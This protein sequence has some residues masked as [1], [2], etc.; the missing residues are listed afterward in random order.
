MQRRD[1]NENFLY[2][3]RL[4][5]YPDDFFSSTVQ[6]ASPAP[7]RLDF[8]NGLYSRGFYHLAALEYRK[9]LQ[10]HPQGALRELALY[11]LGECYR[12]LGKE[13]AAIKIYQEQLEDF[14][15]GERARHARYRL[16]QLFLKRG[17]YE[18]ASGHLERLIAMPEAGKLRE[19]SLLRLGECYQ[20]LGRPQKALLAWSKIDGESEVATWAAFRIGSVLLKQGE[21]EKAL[22]HFARVAGKEESPLYAEANFQRGEILHS[23]GRAND[24][25]K[26]YLAAARAFARAG[27]NE[28]SLFKYILCRLRL[29]DDRQALR[30]GKS[31]LKSFPNSGRTG[32]VL[33]LVGEA[34]SRLGDY[35][36]ALR[37]LKKCRE[38]KLSPP[39]APLAHFRE[40]ECYRQQKQWERAATSFR[41]FIGAFADHPLKEEALLRLGEAQK[42][43]A[44]FPGASKTLER[45][46]SAYPDSGHQERAMYLLGICYAP[47][48]RFDELKD[49][50]ERLLL[51]APE[52][53]YAGE[54]RYWVGRVDMKK[55]NYEKARAHFRMAFDKDK[56]KNAL[57]GLGECSYLLGHKEE[58]AGYFLELVSL[59]PSA[60][61]SRESYLWLGG[62]LREAERWNKALEIY[63]L[64]K[65]NYPVE[66]RSL[67]ALHYGRGRA[68]LALG[69][70]EE[71]DRDF[72]LLIDKFP[73]NLLYQVLRGI[74]LRHLQKYDRAEDYLLKAAQSAEP[75]VAAQAQLELGNVYFDQNRFPE[76]SRLYLRV[77]ILYD[78]PHFSPQAQ[79]RA[80]R[81]FELM[82]R[83]DK[84][85]DCYRELLKRYPGT[86][87]AQEARKRLERL[88]GG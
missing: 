86:V 57:R 32:D 26:A 11:R 70:W 76:A 36:G 16:S 42:E 27:N 19:I 48:K 30:E 29:G 80:G 81:C 31:F 1:K 56:N 66:S 8:A 63:R 58:A 65:E 41:A 44:D 5:G 74:S 13:E 17:D 14:S 69:Q 79:L 45:L 28:G 77:F 59:D 54:A 64:L 47:Q 37:F 10:E 6:A 88:E 72:S 78:H 38:R 24:S 82:K 35:E 15:E 7:E 4:P 23:L 83:P 55:G 51:L 87:Y 68:K 67:E 46:L 53:P 25:R 85:A 20:K 61:L 62:Y 3:A 9:F 40:A 52:G 49:V 22:P 21:K 50:Y 12:L 43:L 60:R 75:A 39:F 34:K 2:P 73:E 33:F 18:T 84:A 71:A